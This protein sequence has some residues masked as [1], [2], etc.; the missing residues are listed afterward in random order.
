MKEIRTIRMVEQTEVKFV[1]DDG[2]EFLTEMECRD[3]ERQADESKVREA[4]DR[5]DVTKISLPV[6]DWFQDGIELWQV[7]LNNKSDF[8][9]LMDYIKVI[10]KPY[11]NYIK[12]PVS[13]PCT[14]IVTLDGDWVSEYE[15]DLKEE[16]QKALAQLG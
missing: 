7:T 11:D 16:L 10:E 13:Y 15:R 4:F 12:E 9:A 5:L 14:K 3:Y 8:V 1:A 2:R 6:L